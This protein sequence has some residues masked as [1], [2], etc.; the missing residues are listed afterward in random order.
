M[1]PLKP[2]F[3]VCEED[4]LSWVFAAVVKVML[5]A[6][7]ML[8]SPSATRLAPWAVMLPVAPVVSLGAPVPCPI[9]A[10]RLI[11]LPL[12]VVPADSLDWVAVF[13][14]L[15]LLDRKPLLLLLTSW[16][17]LAVFLAAKSSMLPVALIV[18]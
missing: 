5:L 13:T 8:M 4:W 14:L 7:R 9:A 2:L 3:L 12:I 6:A 11:A 10:F 16:A 17:K 18:T 1:L 15:L